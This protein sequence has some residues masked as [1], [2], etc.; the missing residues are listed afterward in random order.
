MGELVVG[1]LGEG[2]LH[3]L[4][5]QLVHDGQAGLV[6][7]LLVLHPVEDGDGAGDVDLLAEVQLELGT[8]LHEGS[9]HGQVPLLVPLDVDDLS[10]VQPLLVLSR[11][12]GVDLLVVR[13]EE[14]TVPASSSMS[15]SSA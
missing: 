1:S 2:Q 5:P 7:H 3:L 9:P 10:P 12:P 8:P 13:S 11:Q 6:R 14:E 4:R 15:T